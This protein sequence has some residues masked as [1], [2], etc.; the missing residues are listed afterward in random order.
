MTKKQLDSIL[1]K[2][3][4]KNSETSIGNIREITALLKKIFGDKWTALIENFDESDLPH[5]MFKKLMDYKPK[6]SAK[7]K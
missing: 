1:A 4:G 3:E 5:S 6:K 7:K 2:L